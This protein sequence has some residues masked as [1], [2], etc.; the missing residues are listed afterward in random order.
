[1]NK[2]LYFT[3][4]EQKEFFNSFSSLYESGMDISSI[5]G[6]VSHSA[7]SI[8]IKTVCSLVLQRINTGA[9]LE[10]ALKP[11][12]IYIGRAYAALLTAGEKSGKLDCILPEICADITKQQEIKSS[13]INALVYP[14]CI[15]LLALGVFMLFMFF[16][17]PMFKSI[18]DYEPVN[19]NTLFIAALIKIAAVYLIL[20]AAAFCTVKIPQAQRKFKKIISSLPVIST[21]I[22]NYYF[23]SF[24][25]IMSLSYDAGVPAAHT[26]ELAASVI[27]IDDM[28]SKVINAAKM[29]LNGS[30]IAP[31]LRTAGIF[32]DFALSQTAAGEQSGKLGKM[33]KIAAKDYETKTDNAVKI[34]MKLLGPIVILIAGI[35]TAL[36]LI[37]GYSEYYNALFSII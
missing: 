17:I 11:F 26:L 3:L 7:G 33:L 13:V 18:S 16:I 5:F 2:N 34:I 4:Q 6:A 22:K 12:E 25:Y 19:K 8:K 28:R 35:I 27:S 15:L 36:I 31:A 37:K 30:E 1:M 14:A 29:V 10:T 21:I 32:S 24:F 20:A 23:A 9:S